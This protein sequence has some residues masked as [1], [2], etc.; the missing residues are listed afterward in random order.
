MKLPVVVPNTLRGICD[1][2]EHSKRKSFISREVYSSSSRITE[3]PSVKETR[4]VAYL[5]AFFPRVF[6]PCGFR[7]F[8]QHKFEMN[9]WNLIHEQMNGWKRQMVK[10]SMRSKPFRGVSRQE[11]SLENLGEDKKQESGNEYRTLISKKE[12]KRLDGAPIV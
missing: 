10:Q 3:S 8:R 4:I 11:N 1:K 2:I 12:K 9:E 7:S 6:A 5:Q